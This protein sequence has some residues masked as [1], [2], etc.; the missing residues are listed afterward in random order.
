VNPHAAHP[1]SLAALVQSIWR[2]KGL[3]ATLSRRE[4]EGRYKGSLLGIFWS[5]LTP[6][7]MVTVF[8]FV[9]GEIF[10]ARWAGAK[11]E[12][13]FDFA[14]ALFTG[15]LVYNLFSECI[16]K[17]PALITSNP[18]YVKKIIFPLETL[19]IVTG[20]AALFHFAIAYAVVILLVAAS[21][22][23]LSWTILFTPI[24]IAPL[25]VM[26]TG[27][28]W[29][30]SALGVFIRDIGQIITPALTAMMFLSPIFYPLSSV[31]PKYSWMYSINPITF[32]IEQLRD[33]LL[34]QKGPDWAGL[35]MYSAISLTIAYAGFLF[36]QKIRK[37]FS[38]VI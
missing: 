21:N 14:A 31:S 2:H 24:V 28:T 10:N 13:H 25:I 6:A 33:V 29:M 17:A 36:F 19:S 4:I 8:T 3:I 38:D 32:T 11:T 26:I 23:T 30:L 37:G 20:I 35:T 12:S 5:F 34:H 7:L 16:G 22:W 15:L 1:T 9:F 27:F 18:V